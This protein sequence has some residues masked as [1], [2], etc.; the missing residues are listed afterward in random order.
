MSKHN[1]QLIDGDFTAHNAKDLLLE[2]LSQKINYHKI[3]K[4]N[5]EVRFGNDKEHSKKRIE[6]LIE[7][8][9]NLI[10]WLQSLDERQGI[11]I[12]GTISLVVQP[13]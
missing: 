4:F 1:I 11:T 8:K 5:N 9:E 13:Q 2:L 3:R 12:K 7:E 10:E 6:A